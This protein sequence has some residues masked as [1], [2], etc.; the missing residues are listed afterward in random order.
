M[1]ALVVV[2]SDICQNPDTVCK[3]KNYVH[4]RSFLKIWWLDVFTMQSLNNKNKND[5]RLSPLFKYMVHQNQTE[6]GELILLM[7]LSGVP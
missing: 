4:I 6:V 7:I 3:K 2:D 1:I 5:V